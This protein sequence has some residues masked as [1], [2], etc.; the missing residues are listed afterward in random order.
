MHDNDTKY[1]S[2]DVQSWLEDHVEIL[3]WPAKVP[4]LSIIE[5]L[6]KTQSQLKIKV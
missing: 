5:S 2:K 4:D 3:D 1:A 6:R